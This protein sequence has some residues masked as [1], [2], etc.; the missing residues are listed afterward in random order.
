MRSCP[1]RP[2]AAQ[3]A[4][5]LGGGERVLQV[6]EVDQGDELLR[7]HVG[8]QPP[9]RL[10]RHLGREVPGGV[11]DRADRHVHDALLR[12]EPPQLA[13]ADHGGAEPAE[14]GDDLGDVPADHVP[15]QGGDGGHHHLVAAPD[16]EAQRVPL[17]A[18]RVGAQ[19]RVRRRVVRVGVHRVGA[20]ELKRGRE[21]DV[22]AVER[23]DSGA[24][25]AV[26]G[27]SLDH[28]ARATGL[29]PRGPPPGSS[30]AHLAARASLTLLGQQTSDLLIGCLHAESPSA[31][32]S[33]QQFGLIH[34]T[35]RDLHS[36]LISTLND[37]TF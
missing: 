26:H 4:E 22:V 8:E 31:R 19:D 20:V 12:A 7:R 13:V 6:A 25:P 14:V 33:S 9:D 24:C 36:R 23:D 35:I 34:R 5:R 11:D 21:A 30:R 1:A 17:Q 2:G 3:D 32:G 16:G 10:A 29:R 18:A 27:S 28:G 15:P 37:L